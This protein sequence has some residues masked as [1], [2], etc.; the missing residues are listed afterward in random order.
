M[1]DRAAKRVLACIPIHT[2]Q[3]VHKTKLDNKLK[4]TGTTPK[5]R[6]IPP[7]PGHHTILR[8]R[9][10][11]LASWRRATNFVV[12]KPRLFSCLFAG[13]P[14]L[15]SAAMLSLIVAVNLFVDW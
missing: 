4:M 1:T 11:S 15:N 13:V 14:G 2:I 7:K 6:P 12:S 10:P 9:T 5:V 8:S 3:F